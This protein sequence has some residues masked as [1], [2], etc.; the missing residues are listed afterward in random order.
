MMETCTHGPKIV[1]V[2]TNPQVRLR[3]LKSNLQNK[4]TDRIFIR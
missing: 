3:L 2:A 1:I 4:S